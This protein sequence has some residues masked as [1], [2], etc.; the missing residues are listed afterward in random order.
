[1]FNDI[2]AYIMPAISVGTLLGA[3]ITVLLS[4]FFLSLPLRLLIVYSKNYKVAILCRKLADWLLLFIIVAVILSSFSASIQTS[5]LY[6]SDK[7]VFWNTVSQ[8]M[9]FLMSV[10]PF[11]LIVAHMVNK[12]DFYEQKHKKYLDYFILYLR[13]FKDDKKTKSE[14]QLMEALNRLYSPYAIGR[15]DEFMPQ[16]GAKR[17]YLGKNWQEVVIELQKKAPLILQRVNVSENFLWEFDQ[18][19]KGNHLNKVLF[20]VADFKEYEEF[21]GYI[22]SK[23]GLL[24]PALNASLNCEQIFY[25]LPDGSFRIYKLDNKDAYNNFAEQYLKDHPQHVEAQ[26]TYFHGRG[27]WK[28]LRLAFSPVYDKNIMPGVNRWS[29]IACLFPDFY[30]ICQPISWRILWFS[31]V[32]LLPVWAMQGY[33][34]WPILLLLYLLLMCVMGKNGRTLVWCSQKWESLA[35]FQKRVSYVNYLVVTLGVARLLLAIALFYFLLVNPFGWQVPHYPFA[36]W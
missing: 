34:T 1:M 30:L 3:V 19:V 13:S 10:I 16:Q 2:L 8:S 26:K 14:R 20:W 36:L 15:P 17:I 12:V 22:A 4:F 6:S 32:M 21:R 25:Y 31:I 24:F 18:C 28:E 23:Y 5:V 27:F 9:A 33:F 11:Y 29:W 7:D 35:F